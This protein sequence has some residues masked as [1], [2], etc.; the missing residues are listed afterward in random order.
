MIPES[1]SK[2]YD[3]VNFYSMLF[4]VP[5][6]ISMSVLWVESAGDP[7]AVGSAGESGL[8]QLK[9]I[10]VRDVRENTGVDYSSYSIDPDENIQAGI[11]FLSLQKKRSGSWPEAI[12]AYNQGFLGAKKNPGLANDYLQKVNAKRK[13]FG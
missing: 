10:A 11:R 4:N 2:W 7:Y 12:K 5:A 9:P 6:D 3:K 13:Y 1:V 8:F